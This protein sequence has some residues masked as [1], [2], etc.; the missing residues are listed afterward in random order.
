MRS[1]HFAKKVSEK[2][3]TKKGAGNKRDKPDS[4]MHAWENKR[5]NPSVV[6]C[7][8]VV[9]STVFGAQLHPVVV[10]SLYRRSIH[11]IDPGPRYDPPGVTVKRTRFPDPVVLQSKFII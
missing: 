11:R 1:K 2:L 4:Y 6:L 5:E 3:F 10:S 9:S 7:Q 8:L